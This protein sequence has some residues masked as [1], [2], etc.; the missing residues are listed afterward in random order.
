MIEIR[1]LSTDELLCSVVS[2]VTEIR[3]REHEVMQEIAELERRGAAS[4]LGYRDLPQ[5]L[6]H[7]VRW[8]LSTARRWI[9]NAALLTNEITP[10]GSEL[11]PKLPLTAEAVAEGALSIEHVAVVA[12]VMKTVPAEQEA[13]VVGYARDFEPVTVRRLG[14][15]L[16]YTIHQNDPEPRD[17]KPAPLGNQHSMFWKNGRL[18][19]RAKLD[20]VTGAKYEALLDPLAKP[21]PTTADEG[22][23][24]RSREEREGDALA[25][26]VDLMLRADQLPEHGGEPV[27]LTLTMDYEDLANQ[28]GHA[29]LDNGDRV[30]VEQ[31]RELACNAGIIPMVLGGAG[32]PLNVGRKTRTF[33]AAIR[34]TLVT[35]DRG[36]AFPGCGRPPRQC[37]AHHIQHWANGGDTSVDNAVLLCRH[38]HTLIHQSKWNVKLVNGIP[39]FY[40]P[41]WLDPQQK[42]RRNPINIA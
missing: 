17:P 27:T 25:E 24:L 37:D 38:H 19:I 2:K 1:L 42:P 9:A 18:E 3:V 34:R 29:T 26:L 41:D 20:K 28:V 31:V 36:C 7:A 39:T 14:T 22:P 32:Q 21:R 13:D 35:R 40:A 11:A 4:E 16:A 30:P 5:V 15:K 10:T 6:R 12:E 33:P 8:D 23:D